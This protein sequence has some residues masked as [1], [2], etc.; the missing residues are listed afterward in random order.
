[1]GESTFAAPTGAKVLVSVL[2]LAALLGALAAQW[3][4]AFSSYDSDL[5]TYVLVGERVADGQDMLRDEPFELV[6][7]PSPQVSLAWL[8]LGKVR[9]WSGAPPLVLVRALAVASLLCL[10]FGASVLA[11]RLFEPGL[12][13]ALA[14]LLFWVALPESWS[15]VVLGRYVSIA[16]VALAA[17]A[18][19]D[20]GRSPRAAA[21]AGLFIAL[22]FY[23]HLFGGV[24][25]AG[26]VVVVVI[27]RWRCREAPGLAPPAL[28]VLMG[29]LLASPCLLFAL[30]T[31]GLAR[32]SAH[33]WRPEQVEAFGFL[34]MRPSEV[35]DLLPLGALLLSLVG[36]V[37]PC[38]PERRLAQA[39]GRVGTLGVLLVLLTPFYQAA[40]ELFGAWLVG[41][42]ALLA[43][44]WLTAALALEWIAGD[45]RSRARRVAAAGL[46]VAIAADAS[47]RAARDWTGEPYAFTPAARAEAM[48]LRATIRG[49]LFLAPDLMGYALAAPTLGRPLA[50]PPGHASPFGDFRRQQRRV[51]RAFSANTDECWTALLALY[52]AAAFLLTP[53]P[54]AVVERR[55]W[56]ERFPGATPEAVRERL[57]SLGVLGPSRGGSSFILDVLTPARSAA[58]R[59][60]RA[61]GMGIGPRCREEL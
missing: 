51:H 35:L 48:D 56:Q 27:A 20:L 7:P 16:F 61:G 28:A 58:D 14:F 1:V 23:A 3:S 17:A 24:L 60:A 46:L 9:Q 15:A 6:P 2:T 19:V 26:A 38:R 10:C 43:F 22:A 29:G 36:L 59:P 37:V 21:R 47:G 30:R 42:A 39:I 40:V 4:P 32:T 34:W 31:V 12:P 11:R 41:R 55:I 13:R 5:W 25:A 18:A 50:V 44:P 8:A 33:T 45:G 49:R 57:R 53:A 54:G 52:P